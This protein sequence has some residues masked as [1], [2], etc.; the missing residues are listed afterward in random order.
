[1]KLTKIVDCVEYELSDKNL[2]KGDLVFIYDS[3]NDILLGFPNNPIKL[4]KGERNKNNFFKITLRKPQ[5]IVP[6]YSKRFSTEDEIEKI[7]SHKLNEIDYFQY[8]TTKLEKLR[9]DMYSDIYLTIEGLSPNY[10]LI[11]VIELRKYNSGRGFSYNVESE[12]FIYF[13]TGEVTSL[14]GGFSCNILKNLTA[15]EFGIS[16]HIPTPNEIINYVSVSQ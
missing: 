10:K 5:F 2:R 16:D 6:T 4:K 15:Y 7:V 13:N 8:N 3:E 12:L 9:E 11:N 14:Y 1:M